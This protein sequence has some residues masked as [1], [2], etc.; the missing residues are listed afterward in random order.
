MLKINLFVTFT[1]RTEFSGLFGLVFFVRRNTEDI[2]NQIVEPLWS[3]YKPV[4]LRMK[5][6][7]HICSNCDGFCLKKKEEEFY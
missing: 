5:S 1:K 6:S 2:E 7:Y 4:V 3:N